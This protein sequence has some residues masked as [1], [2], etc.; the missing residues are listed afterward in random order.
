MSEN[1]GNFIG[2]SVNPELRA[3]VGP[4]YAML[5]ITASLVVGLVMFVA[6]KRFLVQRPWQKQAADTGAV[7]INQEA[8]PPLS[9]LQR[10]WNWRKTNDAKAV[11]KV[12]KIYILLIG[13]TRELFPIYSNG[14]LP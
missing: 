1:I 12:V 13:L 11:W 2:E 4:V 9:R 8:G 10:L 7:D 6:G 5:S 14:K 3:T